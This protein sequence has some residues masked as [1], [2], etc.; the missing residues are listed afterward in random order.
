MT[1]TMCYDCVLICKDIYL[2]T[3]LFIEIILIIPNQ[4]TLPFDGGWPIFPTSIST[5]DTCQIGLK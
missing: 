4:V 5:F 3:K 1:M 2:H